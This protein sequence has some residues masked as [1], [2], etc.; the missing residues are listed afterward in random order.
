MKSLNLI[1]RLP[2]Y[3]MNGIFQLLLAS[4]IF[5]SCGQNKPGVTSAPQSDSDST[6]ENKVKQ[7]TPLLLQPSTDPLF[8]LPGQL[9]Q[10]LRNIYEDT[11]GNLWLGT[12]VY[13]LMCYNGDSLKTYTEEDGVGGGRITE[14]VEDQ[15]GN[16][17]F[18]TY[19]GLTKYDGETFTN[20]SEKDGLVHNEVW[21]LLIDSKGIFW[22]GT[23]EGVSRFDGARFTTLLLP[24][25]TV[26][27]P[28]HILSPNRVTS[29]V[30][31]N[32]GLIWLGT[33]GYGICKYR[34]YHT[35]SGVHIT[36]SH[37]T[38][39]SGL[40]DNNIYDLFKDSNDN[41]WI[42]T[43]YG[44]VSLFDGKTF[45]NFTEKGI[46]SGVEVGGFFEDKKGDIWFAA[47]NHGIY[48]YNYSKGILPADSGEELFTI[49]DEKDGL[50][51]GG[52]LCM[53]EDSKGR[54]WLGGWGGLFRFDGTTF[55]GV[56]RTGPWN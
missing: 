2:Q 51:T 43:M 44:G 34:P 32:Q 6:N 20:Y 45:T 52:I 5:S 30:E 36:F 9:C 29:I 21:S 13:G 33:D 27:N 54:F 56:S 17:W 16:I 19:G 39:T 22:I 49:F 1:S 12:N 53:L 24:K 55:S 8:F 26:E 50:M 31:D 3:L 11:Q 28:K 23:L 7:E 14:I 37:L 25:V 15:K 10:H 38:K 35:G 47:E 40:S 42:G 48:R 41:I 18:G 46:I 4:L